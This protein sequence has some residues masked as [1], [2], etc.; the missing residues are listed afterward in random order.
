MTSQALAHEFTCEGNEVGGKYDQPHIIDWN[1]DTMN[2]TCSK[3][4]LKLTDRL[5]IEEEV[6]QALGQCSA[7]PK[8]G[9]PVPCM[10]ITRGD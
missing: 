9:F 3:A 6:L 1:W 7:S 5:R 8:C 2:V 10:G 4:Q